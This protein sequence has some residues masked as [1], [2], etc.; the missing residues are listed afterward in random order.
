MQQTQQELLMVRRKSDKSIEKIVMCKGSFVHIG[1]VGMELG[2]VVDF[3]E[4]EKL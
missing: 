2:A 3:K 1:D 4:I